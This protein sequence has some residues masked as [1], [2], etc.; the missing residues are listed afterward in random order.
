MST[1]EKK[2]TIKFA[3]DTV[4]KQIPVIAGTG[5]NSTSSAIEMSKYAESVGADGL[6]IVTPYYNKATQGRF[7][8]TL[9][10]NC[11]ISFTSN[12]RL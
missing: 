2:S 6:L 3:I 9:Q 11:R 4:Q 5:S 1:E 10:S 8:R 12:Y 7:N